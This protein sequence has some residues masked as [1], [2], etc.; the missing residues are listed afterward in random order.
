MGARVYI[1]AETQCDTTSPQF[2]KFITQTIK[3]KDNYSKV[4][5]G[6]NLEEKY[7]TTY[8]PGGTLI[9]A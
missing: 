5:F 9:G 7:D 8:K 6:S 1:I 4:E 2:S 3:T